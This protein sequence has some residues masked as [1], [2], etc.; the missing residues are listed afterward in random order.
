MALA[1]APELVR[2]DALAPGDMIAM[3][4][5]L[6]TNEQPFF[7]QVPIPFHEQTRNGVFGDARLATAEA[8]EDIVATAVARTVTFIRA[9]LQR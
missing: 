5:P 3:D 6:G 1:I 7:L 8:G 2:R 9:F 4:L